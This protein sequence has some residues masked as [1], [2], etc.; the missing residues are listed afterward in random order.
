MSYF[1]Y[2]FEVPWSDLD[3][4]KSQLYR[5][6]NPTRQTQ[7]DDG[8]SFLRAGLRLIV[9]AVPAREWANVSAM[10]FKL[11]RQQFE[12]FLERGAAASD[13]DP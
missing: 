8:F 6:T 5:R 9:A 10:D 4:S 12:S 2:V 1:G 7:Q 13:C 3:E 11:S